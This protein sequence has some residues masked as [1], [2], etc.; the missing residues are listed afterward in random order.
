[1]PNW[2][3]FCLG[4]VFVCIVLAARHTLCLNS[5]QYSC[6][7]RSVW[8]RFR[9]VLW[10]HLNT[11]Y[12]LTLTAYS[13]FI[14]CLLLDTHETLIF[15]F[16]ILFQWRVLSVMGMG[17]FGSCLLRQ[18]KTMRSNSELCLWPWRTKLR[19]IFWEMYGFRQATMMSQPS[20]PLTSTMTYWSKM[21]NIF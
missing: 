16:L 13:F 17:A 8:L 19:D 9:T 5:S 4:F 18:W 10:K 3:W 12:T 1:M 11:F 20:K 15:H 14:V 2:G 7:C 21:S 6:T